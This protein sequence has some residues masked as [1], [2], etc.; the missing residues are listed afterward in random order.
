MKMIKF[1]NC[2]GFFRFYKGARF[3]ATEP[4][5]NQ[6]TEYVFYNIVHITV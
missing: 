4:G 2:E 6:V 1:P 5:I 3:F